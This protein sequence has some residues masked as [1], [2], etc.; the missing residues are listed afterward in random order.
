MFRETIERPESRQRPNFFFRTRTPPFEILERSEL[1]ILSGVF[2]L[3]AVLLA[4]FVHYAK[5]ESKRV[6]V[7]NR[8]TPIRSL[9]ADRLHFH[10]MSLRVFHNC[11][12]RIKT[13]RL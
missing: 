6:V 11:R 9:H 10:A 4:Q 1:S 7:Q 5:A 13:H 2:N 3:L 8:A 12:G